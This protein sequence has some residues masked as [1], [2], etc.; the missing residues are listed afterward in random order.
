MIYAMGVNISGLIIQLSAFGLI[1]YSRLRECHPFLAKRSQSS[2]P[3]PALKSI[4]FRVQALPG[5][6]IRIA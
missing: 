3:F 6:K 2:I 1:Q 5:L 4:F